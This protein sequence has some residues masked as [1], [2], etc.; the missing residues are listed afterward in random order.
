MECMEFLSQGENHA[1]LAVAMTIFT[2]CFV[3]LGT[4]ISLWYYAVGFC[5]LIASLIYW[6]KVKLELTSGQG[7]DRTK[8]P[9]F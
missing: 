4:L 6:Q 9:T 2:F 3:F 5:F 7:Y 8:A 1:F